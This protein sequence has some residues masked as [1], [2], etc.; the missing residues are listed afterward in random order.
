VK[1]NT[2]WYSTDHLPVIK[3]LLEKAADE[4]RVVSSIC[5]AACTSRL[6][7]LQT[8][9]EAIAWHPAIFTLAF[10]QV[11]QANNRWLSKEGIDVI[12]VLLRHGASGEQVNMAL[13]RAVQAYCSG[14]S[15]ERLIDA[16]LG[17][18]AD[19][20]YGHGEVVQ[21]ATE[22]GDNMLLK[23]LLEHGATSDT[24]DRALSI[25]IVA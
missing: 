18:N 10:S 23:K 8:F 12:L 11:I 2:Q 25:G 24:I 1:S 4:P 13:I 19:V 15:H 9:A 21:L 6:E 17:F 22:C 3:I 20:N 16:L 7:V 5:W 14:G